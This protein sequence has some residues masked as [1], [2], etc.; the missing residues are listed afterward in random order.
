MELLAQLMNGSL[1]GITQDNLHVNW[2]KQSQEDKKSLK[3][4]NMPGI[5]LNGEENYYYEENEPEVQG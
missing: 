2:G 3:N 5:A 4:R 1:Q